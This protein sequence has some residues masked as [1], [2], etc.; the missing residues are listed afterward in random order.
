MNEGKIIKF[1]VNKKLLL[2]IITFIIISGVIIYGAIQLNLSK[3]EETN[4]LQQ[5]TLSET[6][7][8]ISDKIIGFYWRKNL[9]T[10][11]Q[12]DKYNKIVTKT[13]AVL[14]FE[15]DKQGTYYK[16]TD[17]TVDNSFNVYNHVECD[18]SRNFEYSIDNGIFKYQLS[19]SDKEN[20]LNISYIND[21]TILIDNEI[22]FKDD[23]TNYSGLQCYLDDNNPEEAEEIL[24]NYGVDMN[25]NKI[26]DNTSNNNNNSNSN[27]NSNNNSSNNNSNNN[28]NS[29]ENKFT[30]HSISFSTKISETMTLGNINLSVK[31]NESGCKYEVYL[32]GAKVKENLKIS[33][34]T[35]GYDDST[36]IEN[37]TI[38]NNE[39]KVN[40]IKDGKIV[41]TDIKNYNFN[42]SSIPT[43]TFSVTKGYN[44]YDSS[45]EVTIWPNKNGCDNGERCKLEL[46]VNGTKQNDT[47][48]FSVPLIIGDNTFK[49]ELKNL[50]GKSSCKK[51]II[52]R[53]EY[54]PDV[55]FTE[56]GNIDISDC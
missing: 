9:K 37:I 55:N 51:I 23:Y 4:N 50:F 46:Y 33:I 26:E 12:Q 49:V 54:N 8:D 27:S 40:L 28:S 38:G 22:F 24:K 36:T 52:K 15:N 41:A 31:T 44:T 29:N 16:L 7:E 17:T 42:L 56:L 20:E 11:K 30:E 35:D 45:Y 43:P 1:V 19:R 6:K 5:E 2:I 21:S 39:I 53:F 34:G 13:I 10:D 47:S 32:N 18:V 25:G 14:Y 3:N 48:S